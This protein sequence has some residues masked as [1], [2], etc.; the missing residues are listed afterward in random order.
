M[1]AAKARTLIINEYAKAF[2]K[3]DVILTPV[4]PNP[5]FKLGEKV[6]DPVAMYLEDVR[7]VPLNL[8]GVPGLTVPAG[9]TE[10]GLDLGLQLV[11]PRRSDRTLVEFAKV[12]EEVK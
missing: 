7:S 9:K 11:G 2:E 10:S 6:N 12:L 8:A 5:A 1:K 4:A 3:C